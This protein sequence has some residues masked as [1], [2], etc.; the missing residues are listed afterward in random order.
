MDENYVDAYNGRGNV[1]Y[2][3]EEYEKAL[4]DYNK[5]LE[6]DSKYV[7]AYK[8]RAKLYRKLGRISEAE[9]DEKMAESLKR[10]NNKK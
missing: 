2:D 7:L 9:A 1:Y 10:S 3:Q 8:N 5:A 4:D 6:L